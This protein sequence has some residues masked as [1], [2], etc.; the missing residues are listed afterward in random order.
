MYI[1]HMSGWVRSR[2]WVG[3]VTCL[4]GCGQMS[5]WMWSHACMLYTN[6]IMAVKKADLDVIR[7]ESC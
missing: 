2:V 7:K 3:V 6:N 4:G 5:G 1:S